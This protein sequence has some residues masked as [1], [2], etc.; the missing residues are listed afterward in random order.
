MDLLYIYRYV[1]IIDQ[2]MLLVLVFSYLAF[3]SLTGHFQRAFVWYHRTPLQYF[4]WQTSSECFFIKVRNDNGD[5]R[6]S[7][8][9]F[10]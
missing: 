1:I 6:A 7:I 3:N 2:N 4:N 8:V 5:G 10:D 9:H